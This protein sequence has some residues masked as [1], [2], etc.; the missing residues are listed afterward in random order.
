MKGGNRL[1]MERHVEAEAL[2]FGVPAAD[3]D[4]GLI[5]SGDRDIVESQA[6]HRG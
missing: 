4:A 1:G 5:G 3:P 6:E 2:P